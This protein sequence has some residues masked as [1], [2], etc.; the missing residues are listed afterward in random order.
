VSTTPTATP[1][2]EHREA[3]FAQLDAA[4]ADIEVPEE[5]AEDV[6]GGIGAAFLVDIA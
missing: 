2:D 5:T 1:N 6:S 4:P 3:A